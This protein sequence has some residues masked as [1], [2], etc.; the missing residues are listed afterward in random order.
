MDER[1]DFPESEMPGVKE[2]AP[3]LRVGVNDALV[4]L[5]LDSRQHLVR[6]HRAEFQKDDEQA[7]KVRKHVAADR[8]ALRVV[9]SR[10]CRAQIL[11]RESAMT[12]IE[13]VERATEERAHGQH[14]PHRQQADERNR[15]DDGEVLEPV[16]ERWAWA[17]GHHARG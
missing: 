13:R 5:D 1:V 15:A 14:A 17:S 16:P 2:L 4:S 12:S 9:P 10:K 11:D 8:L 3:V 6:P 7:A